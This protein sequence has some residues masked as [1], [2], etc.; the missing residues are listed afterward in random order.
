MQQ[1]PALALLLACLMAVPAQAQTGDGS[2]VSGARLLALCSTQSPFCTGYVAGVVDALAP[3]SGPGG[4]LPVNSLA[5]FC[6]PKL[7]IKQI[8]GEFQKFMKS[9]PEAAQTNAAQLVGDALHLAHPC[10]RR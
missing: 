3:L 4:P 10:E 7:T 5:S 1:I 2:F 6:A 8:I 9:N